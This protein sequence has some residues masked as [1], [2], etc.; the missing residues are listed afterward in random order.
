MAKA[1]STRSSTDHCVFGQPS[2]LAENKL[3]TKLEILK[4]VRFRQNEL[5]NSGEPSAKL[6]PVASCLFVLFGMCSSK[7]YNKHKH[8]AEKIIKFP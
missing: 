8:T 5:A 2:P 3:P 7:F 4:C 1:I 6:F